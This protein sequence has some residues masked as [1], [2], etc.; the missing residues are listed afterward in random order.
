MTKR[1]IDVAIT[2]QTYERLAQV[3]EHGGRSM[4]WHVERALE[5]H[6]ELEGV[7]EDDVIASIAPGRTVPQSH[8]AAWFNGEELDIRYYGRY[9]RPDPGPDRPMESVEWTQAAFDQATDSHGPWVEYQRDFISKVPGTLAFLTGRDSGRRK[10]YTKL[11][12]WRRS[13]RH[14]SVDYCRAGRSVIILFLR[15]GSGVEA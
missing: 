7:D 2:A 14:Y 13:W 4:D 12:V 15:P 1:T 10:R 5:E 6:L 8:A 9:N 3:V 11:A